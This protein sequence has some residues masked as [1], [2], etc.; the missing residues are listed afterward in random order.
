MEHLTIDDMIRFVSLS[1]LNDAAVELS[2]S[3]NGHIR[4]CRSCLNRVNAF[5]MIYD[6][7][8]EQYRNGNFRECMQE[9]ILE[10]SAELE[11]HC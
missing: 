1:E 3:V 5:Q 7:F 4:G 6:E 9:R 10:L 11:N 2:A 8:T